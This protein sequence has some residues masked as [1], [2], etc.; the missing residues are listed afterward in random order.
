M[1]HNYVE[2]EDDSWNI[3]DIGSLA[4]LKIVK[5]MFFKIDKTI[6]FP[7]KTK[8]F[9]SLFQNR[10]G[11]QI[12]YLLLKINIIVDLKLD[13]LW[14]LMIQHGKRIWAKLILVLLKNI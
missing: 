3:Y 4:F 12:I 1:W 8:H 10:I 5:E 9:I 6:F 13:F 14:K 11:F 2:R 7:I